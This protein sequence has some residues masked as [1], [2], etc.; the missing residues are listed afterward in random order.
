L[1]EVVREYDFVGGQL[2][3][4]VV[5]RNNS[6][7][8]IHDVKVILDVPSSYNRKTD[9]ITIPTIDPHNS[10]GVDFYLEPQECGLS[11]I[12]GT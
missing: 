2:H 6:D 12:G 9:I 1:V 5:T 11:T 10:R 8:T 7:M 3:F 4:K